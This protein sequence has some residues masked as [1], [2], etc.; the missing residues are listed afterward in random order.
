VPWTSRSATIPI[1]N[2]SP[3]GNQVVMSAE[4]SEYRGR[5]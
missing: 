4:P 1:A 3:R 5:P 2:T